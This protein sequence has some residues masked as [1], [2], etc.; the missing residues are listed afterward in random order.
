M[1]DH[2]EGFPDPQIAL[3][4]IGLRD[5]HPRSIAN[6]LNVPVRTYWRKPTE[7]PLGL[8]GTHIYAA[9]AHLITIIIVPISAMKCNP[10]FV[11]IGHPGHT[12]QLISENIAGNLP[13]PHV[14]HGHFG[15][16]VEAAARSAGGDT[17]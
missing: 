4:T 3:Q 10:P 2:A 13:V 8:I 6:G 7:Q 17:I 11:E 16:Y 15:E 5:I 1:Q 12:R 9:M 14:A